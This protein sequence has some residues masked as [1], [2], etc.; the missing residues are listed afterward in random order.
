MFEPYQLLEKEYASF[1]GSGHAVSC[2]SGTSALH[3]A[4]LCLDVKAGDEV[5]VPDFTM[6]ACGFAVSYTG[7]T[8][9]FVDVNRKNYGLDPK[10]VEKAITPKTKAIMVVHVY[11]RLA[12]MESILKIAR[13]HGLFVIEDA[14]EAQGAIK[15][16]KADITVYSFYRNKIIAAEEGG[17]LTTNTKIIAEKARYL[18]NMAFD[19]DH[20]YYHHDIGYN[21]RMPN[22]Q[23][24]LALKSLADYPRNAE[25]RRKVEEWYDAEI[26]DHLPKR[27]A[28][29]FYDVVVR[30][31]RILTLYPRARDSFKPLSSF[32]M[33]GRMRIN[34]V[35]SF[36]ANTTVLL[37]VTPDLDRETIKYI[38]QLLS[39]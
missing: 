36:L 16:S 17:M 11:G 9:V 21:Y 13:K 27:D 24:E 20:S 25:A 2:N 14:C 30:N 31:K 10:L 35:A 7:A 5:I 22:S 23:A 18:K 32:P 26:P 38:C 8:P 39:Q 3:L 34:K 33:Y 37:P 1:T 29:W 4:L 28:V 12:P 19:S 6:A 15:A